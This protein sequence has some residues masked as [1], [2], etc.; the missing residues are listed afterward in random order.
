MKL[1]NSFTKLTTEEKLIVLCK[2]I[3]DNLIN[4]NLKL[5]SF[6]FFIKFK[7]LIFF[8]QFFLFQFLININIF[9]Y[10][11]VQFNLIDQICD[12]L[13]LELISFSKLKR[14]R[15]Y[16]DIILFIIMYNIYR[17]IH[18]EYTFNKSMQLVVK[19]KK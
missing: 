12:Y 17:R 8:N 15:N 6:K 14:L 3:I 10:A 16:S 7:Y 9:D 18:F 5:F 2:I 13:D 1:L 11:F 19:Y 4:V